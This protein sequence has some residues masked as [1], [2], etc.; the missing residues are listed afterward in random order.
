MHLLYT[1]EQASP[2]KSVG[3]MVHKILPGLYTK[4]RI[5]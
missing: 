4:N 2:N 5:L 3:F 1:V